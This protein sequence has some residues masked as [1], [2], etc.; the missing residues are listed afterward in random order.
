MTHTGVD[1]VVEDLARRFG[2]RWA[3]ARVS[4]EVPAGAALMVT[5]PNGSG[6]TTLLRCLATA[7]KPHHGS[8][9]LDGDD[10]WAGRRG[11][12]SS[13]GYLAHA[14]RQYDDLSAMD[15]LRV[16]ARL[17]DL[18]VDLPALLARVSLPADRHDAVRTFS[19]GMRRR[20]ALAIA[21]LK[22]PAFMLLDEPFSAI[23]P[24]G[25]KLMAT[26]LAELRDRGT[27]LVMTSHLPAEAARFCTSAIHLDDGRLVWSGTP[28]DAVALGSRA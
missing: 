24:A 9:T 5:G 21:L 25:R 11:W 14:A 16:W 19:A 2:R 3:L 23:D 15:N 12:R 20:L 10:L 4:F 1:L 8:I 7:L 27:T 18:D 13:I 28:E 26:I 17:G 22:Q 6:K